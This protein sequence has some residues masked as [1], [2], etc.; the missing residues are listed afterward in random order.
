[1]ATLVVMPRQGQSVES[2][3]IGKWHKRKGDRVEPGDILFT[4]ETDKATF[5]EM[6]NTGGMLLDVFFEEGDDVECLKGVCVIGE[7]GEDINEFRPAPTTAA[8]ADAGPAATPT[9][10][11]MT[12]MTAAAM[13]TVPTASIAPVAPTDPNAPVAPAEPTMPAAIPP[14]TWGESA[15][16]AEPDKIR[17]SPRARQLALK[18]G[19]DVSRAQPTGAQGRI[20]SDDI[21]RAV[22]QGH[23][24]TRAAQGISTGA[25]VAGTGLG[26]RVGTF[27]MVAGSA[28]MPTSA[29]TPTLALAPASALAPMSTSTSPTSP[30]SPVSGSAPAPTPALV[31]TPAP[32]YEEVK[33][34]RVRRA[35][36]KAMHASL[37]GAAQL[38]LHSSFDAAEIFAFRKKLKAVGADGPLPGITVTDMIIYAAS[39]VLG[40]HKSVNAHFLGDCMRIYRDAHIGVAVDTPRGLLVPTL[41][42]A[43]TLSLSE[44]SVSAKAMFAKCREGAVGPDMLTGATFTI[45]NLGTLGIEVFTPILNPPQTCLLGVCA[46]VERTR[47]GKPYPAMGLS[48]TFDHRALDGADAARF[49]KDIV[50]YLESFSV[51]LAL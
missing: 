1:M 37:A 35:I 45:S 20:I 15:V 6:A 17:I 16:P 50:Q 38:T 11:A 24:V 29:T 36:A 19:A 30:V 22:E 31:G 39:R 49:L 2:C 23:F 10:T 5:E 44:I 40:R 48:L 46:V 8:H 13:E 9:A 28:P 27:D 32:E 43:N 21:H 18:T 3:V 51:F 33:L 26:G 7:E 47:E 25:E 42:R 14:A 34:S 41:F 12:A 4:Y